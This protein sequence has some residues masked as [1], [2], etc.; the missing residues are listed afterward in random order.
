M[1]EKFDKRRTNA[2]LIFRA[3]MSMRYLYILGILMVSTGLLI[4]CKSAPKTPPVIGKEQGLNKK[5][6]NDGEGTNTNGKLGETVKDTIVAGKITVNIDAKL[7]LPSISSIPTAKVIPQ[8]FGQDTV[9]KVLKILMKGKQLYEPT[10][11]K[12]KKDIQKMMIL[13][14]ALNR[15]GM[16]N[17][18][19][20]QVGVKRGTEEQWKEVINSAPETVTKQPAK[21]KLEDVN[22]SDLTGNNGQVYKGFHGKSLY[23]VSNLGADYDADLFINSSASLKDSMIRFNNHDITSVYTYSKYTGAARGMNTS[24]EAAKALAS[25]TLE[26]LGV[27]DMKLSAIQLAT[28]IP[29]TEK[30]DPNKTN[31]AYALYFTR[32]VY[33]IQT[34]MDFTNEKPKDGEY[35][36]AYPYEQIFMLIDDSGI[37]QFN[38]RSPMKLSTT[39]ATNTKILPFDQILDIFKKQFFIHYANNDKASESNSYNIDRITLGLMRVQV[40]DKKDEYMMIPVWDFFGNPSKKDTN[41]EQDAILQRWVDSNDHSFKSFLT[42]NAIDGS[43]I[44]RRL[45]Y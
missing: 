28:S 40:K 16:L 21:S 34:T 39:L 19:D 31:Q 5:I 18:K 44:D 10:G 35:E 14:Q 17:N 1:K 2:N 6:L 4:S 27:S 30:D 37:L 20:N 13:S 15:Q 8:G 42:I 32:N 36:E 38:W 26:E 12:T 24:F 33:G 41:L 7:E 9:D 43:I 11:E 45:G 29:L 3:K 23:V 25:K 22:E